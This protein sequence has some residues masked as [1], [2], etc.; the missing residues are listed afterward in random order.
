MPISAAPFPEASGNSKRTRG[1]AFFGFSVDPRHS[2]VVVGG[3]AKIRLR[4]GNSPK[5]VP[6]IGV[7][8]LGGFPK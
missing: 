8:F 4:T 6:F 7:F 3:R 1:E 5:R 2:F